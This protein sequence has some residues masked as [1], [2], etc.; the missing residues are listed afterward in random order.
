MAAR[1]PLL[2]ALLIVSADTSPTETTCEHEQR[3]HP[4]LRLPQL[5]R[6]RLRSRWRTSR[7]R[8]SSKAWRGYSFTDGGRPRPRSRG[9]RM[10]AQRP[11]GRRRALE[12]LA[13]LEQHV[14]VDLQQ[15]RSGDVEGRHQHHRRDDPAAPI[16]PFQRGDSIGTGALRLRSPPIRWSVARRGAARSTSRGETEWLALRERLT[17]RLD[18]FHDSHD[19]FAHEQLAIAP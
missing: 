6:P 15:L 18:A 5:R 4:R 17:D 1:G 2:F 13:H 16:H 3:R 7:W 19:V 11:E 8:R 14:G 10:H 12:G 9:S